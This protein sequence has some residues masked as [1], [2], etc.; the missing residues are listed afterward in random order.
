MLGEPATL[1]PV[2]ESNRLACVALKVSPAQHGLVGSN[3]KSLGE[4]ATNP[5]LVPRV[6]VQGDTVVGFAMYQRRADGSAYI[7][8]V[9]VGEAYQGK[10]L[11]RRLMRLLLAELKEAG[12]K[13]VIISHRPQNRVAAHLF[14]SFGFEEQDI[15]PDGEVM[16]LLVFEKPPPA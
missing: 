12:F 14:E 3:E 4:A 15:E 9:M 6:L 10:G 11:G 8:R 7:W 2:D 5:S 1:R 16:R 13:S